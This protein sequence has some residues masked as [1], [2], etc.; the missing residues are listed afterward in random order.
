MY[1]CD[2]HKKRAPYPWRIGS[3][4]VTMCVIRNR[5]A[6]DF[7]RLT[8][9]HAVKVSGIVPNRL[10]GDRIRLPE[11]GSRAQV[12]PR[13]GRVGVAPFPLAPCILFPDSCF[14]FPVSGHTLPVTRL[15]LTSAGRTNGKGNALD[16]VS[17][18][19]LVTAMMPHQSNNPNQ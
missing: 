5:L 6:V 18:N 19:G 4:L 2:P 8:A 15:R 1:M 7:Q 12:S 16:K 3:V 13:R 11:S 17:C 10:S 9:F 14:R